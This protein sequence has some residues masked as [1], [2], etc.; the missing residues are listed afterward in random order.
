M[1]PQLFFGG[2][3]A[4]K[5]DALGGGN[6]CSYVREVLVSVVDLFDNVGG[7]LVSCGEVE[8]VVGQ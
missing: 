6:T 2:D 3:S 7:V 4:R 5:D 1:F 8:K